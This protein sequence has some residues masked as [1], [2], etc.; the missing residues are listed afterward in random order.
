M[1]K[2]E[3][4]YRTKMNLASEH[5]LDRVIL[6]NDK[7]TDAH[8]FLWNE[9]DPLD[10]IVINEAGVFAGEVTE[11]MPEPG[12]YVLKPDDFAYFQW[13]MDGPAFNTLVLTSTLYPIEVHDGLGFGMAL[14]GGGLWNWPDDEFQF[15]YSMES[16]YLTQVLLDTGPYDDATEFTYSM[17]SG[18]LTTILLTTGPYNDEVQF[19]YSME[20]GY[21]TPKLV[22]GDTRD[23]G[24]RFGIALIGG[25]L[26][27]I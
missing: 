1:L 4:W 15:N 6:H 13:G 22:T 14:I 27:N 9:V 12:T 2:Q 26:D 5:L 18:Y 3:A 7:G 11:D 21:L 25:S 20:S 8:L 16:G 23:D 10:D 17:Q 19:N 24:L